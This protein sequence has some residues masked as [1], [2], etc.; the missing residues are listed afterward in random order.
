MSDPPK[1]G[2]PPLDAADPS[3]NVHVRMPSKVYDAAWAHA[4]ADRLSV[5]EWIRRTLQEAVV[6]QN[7]HQ[8]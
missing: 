8:K 4:Q 6:T 1:P 3:V 2:R 7:R 5:P